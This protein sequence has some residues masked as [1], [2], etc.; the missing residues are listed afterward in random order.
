MQTKFRV[1]GGECTWQFCGS[2]KCNVVG[3]YC[4][5]RVSPSPLLGPFW[6]LKVFVKPRGL[7]VGLGLDNNTAPKDRTGMLAWL[8]LF[9]CLPHIEIIYVEFI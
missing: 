1:V 5:F 7:G 8:S 2:V 6:G 3:S 9:S 4:D